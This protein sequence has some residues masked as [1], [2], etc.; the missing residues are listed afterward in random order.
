MSLVSFDR[1]EAACFLSAATTPASAHPPP[2]SGEVTVS[3]L[4]CP[5]FQVRLN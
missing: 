4:Q 3:E 5:E 2:D 1:D